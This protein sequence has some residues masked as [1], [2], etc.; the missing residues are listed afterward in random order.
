M[1]TST[2]LALG[3][4]VLLALLLPVVAYLGSV[5]HGVVEMN[6]VLTTSGTSVL[7]NSWEQMEALHRFRENTQKWWITDDPRYQALADSAWRGFGRRLEELQALPA[8]RGLVSDCQSN[9]L[10][11][12]LLRGPADQLPYDG[13]LPQPALDQVVPVATGLPLQPLEVVP[14]PVHQQ[15]DDRAKGGDPGL[16]SE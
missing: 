1:R 10:F 13:H 7:V 8:L 5:I 3:F 2:R 9:A 16:A 6:R 15:A 12:L 4:S 14:E 11:V